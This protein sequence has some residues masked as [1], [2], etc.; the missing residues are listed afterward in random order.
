MIFI[1]LTNVLE[2]CVRVWLP[3]D[4]C[5]THEHVFLVSFVQSHAHIW[6]N[7]SLKRF[8]GN[9]RLTIFSFCV[10]CLPYRTSTKTHTL[11]TQSFI[12]RV[13]FIDVYNTCMLVIFDLIA[14]VYMFRAWTVVS[15]STFFGQLMIITWS[16]TISCI[17]Y[18]VLY[19]YE[20]IT[21][22]H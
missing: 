9:D 4:C 22:C 17:Y 21:L 19:T 11:H 5:V 20:Y 16:Q 18:C 6:L 15:L 7:N 13:S 10:H 12:L 2:V 3:A 8:V 14:C 1:Y